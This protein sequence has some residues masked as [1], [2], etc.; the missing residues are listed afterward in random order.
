M[1]GAP[2]LANNLAFD[3]F[4]QPVVQ[5][6]R[7]P[8]Y[9]DEEVVVRND[10]FAEDGS[11]AVARDFP[12]LAAQAYA[13]YEAKLAHERQKGLSIDSRGIVT[14]NPVA[15]DVQD[16]IF[17]ESFGPIQLLMG[18]GQ[19]QMRPTTPMVRET[20]GGIY[21][22]NP[23]SGT[24]ELKVEPP[25]RPTAPQKFP[26]A[27]EVDMFGNPG[28][29]KNFSATDWLNM[30]PMLPP[31]IRTNEPV[32]SYMDWGRQSNS[33]SGAQSPFPASQ[34]L[35]L[36][37]SKGELKTGMTYETAKGRATWDGAKFVQ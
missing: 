10:G 15:P 20:A 2:S 14:S 18:G 3:P 9:E 28:G 29:V 26:G 33:T 7:R 23:Q 37:K 24:W 6:R 13:D 11:Y 8:Q 22:R 1:A 30:S 16:A 19:R 25:K 27:T 17:Q 34:A 12:K 32:A 5:R 31:Q 35:P 21:E 36:P 4:S